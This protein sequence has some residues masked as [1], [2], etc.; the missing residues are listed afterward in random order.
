MP[1]TISTT[2]SRAAP[3]HALALARKSF[4]KLGISDA[5]VGQGG[6]PDA[7]T[8]S[9]VVD[10]SS[11]LSS[12]RSSLLP[13]FRRTAC[14]VR[15]VK[16]A[17]ATP[18]S[19]VAE[20]LAACFRCPCNRWLKRRSAKQPTPIPN[21]STSSKRAKLPALPASPA[22]ISAQHIDPC[23]LVERIQCPLPAPLPV[24]DEMC[25]SSCTH[26]SPVQTASWWRPQSAPS[27][28][29]LSSASVHNRAF[30][31]WQCVWAPLQ[32]IEL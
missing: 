2:R 13:S 20:L 28:T 15:R 6:M 22:S 16:V 8:P 26:S 24:G 10:I 29:S 32:S 31:P 7:T 12:F 30:K 25:R 27:G 3:T 4:R 1:P 14:F 9:V 23:A 5:L 11:V 21:P 18:S 19:D 17:S